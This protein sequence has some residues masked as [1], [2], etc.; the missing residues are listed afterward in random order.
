MEWI[1]LIAVLLDLLIGDPPNM[2]HPVIWIGKAIQSCET[3]VHRH[4]KL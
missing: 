3:V 1:I 2:P 4:T